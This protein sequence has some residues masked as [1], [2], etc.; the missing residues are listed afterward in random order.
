MRCAI[1]PDRPSVL[2]RPAP[3]ACTIEPETIFQRLRADGADGQP[4]RPGHPRI[5]CP[6]HAPSS[7]TFVYRHFK[8]ATHRLRIGKRCGHFRVLQPPVR[9]KHQMLPAK[10]R[11]MKMCFTIRNFFGMESMVGGGLLWAGE[12][13]AMRHTVEDIV[14]LLSD[15]GAMAPSSESRST[16]SSTVCLIATSSPAHSSPPPTMD[17]MPKK[18]LIVKHIFMNRV[19]AGS[20]WCFFRTGGWST[21]KCPHRLP[22]R[23]R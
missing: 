4:A 6:I 13:V 3:R 23:N 18:F 19:F 12:E 8:T 20:I 7:R 21:R 14:L 1:G 9:K 16:M 10:T 2:R 5:R 22:M 15:E 11:F 17:S